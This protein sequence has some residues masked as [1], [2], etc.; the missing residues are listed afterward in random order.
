MLAATL[1][2][3][4]L[5]G[6]REYD[7]RV[8]RYETLVV[9]HSAYIYRYACWLCRNPTLAED[10]VQ[11]TFLRAWRS[12]DQLQ[13]P[14]AIKSWLTTIVRREHAR[15]YQRK[16]PEADADPLPEWLI[17]DCAQAFDPEADALRRAL[18][19][20]SERYSEPLVLQ[21]IGGYSCREIGEIIGVSEGAVMTRLFRARNK[22]R[23]ILEGD[24]R[25]CVEQIP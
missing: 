5:R 25:E 18:N 7:E 12:L 15:L 16:R 6:D 4:E 8:E 24:A 20:I 23:E 11:E 14:H 3:P 1:Q 22:L 21:V 17:D 13:D 10:L 19:S 9:A 2:S